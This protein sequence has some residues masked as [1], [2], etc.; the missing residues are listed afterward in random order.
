MGFA[1]MILAALAATLSMAQMAS[2]QVTT[3]LADHVEIRG[4]TVLFASGNVEYLAGDT[5]ILAPSVTYDRLSG[6]VTIAGPITLFQGESTVI[7]ASQAELDAG[8]ANG[9]MQNA[10]LILDEQLQMAAR[11]L[12]RVDGRYTQLYKTVASSCQICARNPIP[13]WQIRAKRVV[14]DQQE[15]QLYFYDA[16]FRALGVPL[17]YLPRLRMPDPTVKRARGLLQ[18]SARTSNLLGIGGVLPYFIPIGD[19]ADITLT[20]YVSAQTKT[21]ELRYRQEFSKGNIGL[22]SAVSRDS[23]LPGQSRAYL[24]ANG[25]FKLPRDLTLAFDIEITSDASYLSTYGYSDKDRLDDA[26]SLTRTK[27]GEYLN[28]GLL[29]FE[30]LRA[31]EL[32]IDDQLPNFQGEFSYERRFFPASIGGQGFW[33]LDIQGHRRSSSVD[34]NGRDVLRFGAKVNWSR[35]HVSG[36]GIVMRAGGGLTS[37]IYVITQDTNYA[38]L[39]ARFTPA[40]EA[41]LRWPHSRAIASGGHQIIEPVAHIGWAESF[42]DTPPDEDSTN[43]EFDEGNLYALSRFHGADRIEN[44]LR[45][46]SGISWTHLDPDGWNLG[47]TAARVTRLDNDNQFSDA[48]G[49]NGMNSDW[50]LAA[51]YKPNGRIALETRA[52]LADGLSITKAEARLKLRTGRLSLS[53]NYAWIIAD[54]LENRASSASQMAFSGSYTI[55]RH[56]TGS[57]DARYDFDTGGPTSASLGLVY[58]NECITADVSLSRSYSSSPSVE[59]KTDIGFS[60]GLNGFGSDG[61][62]SRRQCS[63]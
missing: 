61:R 52:L 41:E 36:S 10:R 26:I 33:K 19:H 3:M 22:K 4:D 47:L 30:T 44:G 24:F 1:R 37:D 39:S 12:T 60:I 13:L 2:G 46:T 63:E 31:S 40:L 57:F 23:L 32:P 7:L 42:G 34:Q 55:S 29:G 25:S 15:K 20:P 38:P 9:I 16:Q 17:L 50:L 62:A 18:P 6:Q 56:L 54:P 59:P 45:L 14:H 49:L 48:S 27:R 51:R 35:E 58:R 8:L 21:L 5:R 11:E 43:V 28:A 53:S